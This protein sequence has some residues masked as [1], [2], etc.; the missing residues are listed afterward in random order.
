MDDIDKLVE[1]AEFGRFQQILWEYFGDDKIL[2]Y[3]EFASQAALEV[4]QLLDKLGL[5]G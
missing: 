3:P 2:K 5:R 4:G 1:L